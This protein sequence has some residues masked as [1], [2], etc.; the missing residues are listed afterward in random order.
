MKFTDKFGPVMAD[1]S[2]SLGELLHDKDL[3]KSRRVMES[4]LQMDKIDLAGLKRA[5]GQE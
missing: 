5:Q 2:D 4:M 3:K 1:H